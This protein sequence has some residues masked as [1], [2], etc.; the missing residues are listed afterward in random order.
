MGRPGG[1]RVT[2]I[3]GHLPCQARECLLFLPD[4]IPHVY[5]QLMDLSRGFNRQARF[6]CI[7]VCWRAAAQSQ[8]KPGAAAVRRP[9]QQSA[10]PLSAGRLYLQTYQWMMLSRTLPHFSASEMPWVMGSSAFQPS[11]RAALSALA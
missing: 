10:L 7:G 1:Q 5:Q 4:K 6:F 3:P 9:Q 2:E 8:H 11:R